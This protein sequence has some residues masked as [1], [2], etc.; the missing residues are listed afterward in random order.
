MP[1]VGETL[2][3][4]RQQQGLELS[5][6]AAQ[7][8]INPKYLEA[9][10]SDNR[11]ILPSGFFYKSFVDQYAKTLALDT[12][13][14][15]AEVD[16]VL[17]ADEPLPLPGF[18]NIVARNVPPMRSSRPS[19]IPR[20]LASAAAFV[21]VLAGC[22]G[23]YELWH[24][25]TSFSMA[26]IFGKMRAVAPPAPASQA[27]AQRPAPKPAP[28]IVEA[29]A[30]TLPPIAPA[31]PASAP[32]A[33]A[34]NTIAPEKSDDKSAVPTPKVLVDLMAREATWLSV[35]SD[36][37]PVFSGTLLPN[38][39]KTVSGNQFAKVRI[40]NAAGIEVR[41]NGKL[42][43]PLGARGQVLTVL[44]TPNSFEVV[45]PPKESD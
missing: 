22:T 27:H 4:A 14:I 1:S 30:A 10:E 40:G 38:E 25:R 20:A 35:S 8:K 12:H 18:E 19:Q 23:I 15:E 3:R 11:K 34:T 37:K 9:I 13:E 28:Q 29:S 33:V 36:G 41:L 26:G 42:L 5:T 45:A 31:K 16:R 32:G 6:V 21:L 39:T 24:A 43:A 44:F 7:T 2:R 17:S